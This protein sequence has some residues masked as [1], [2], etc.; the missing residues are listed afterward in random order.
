M[1][2]MVSVGAGRPYR[3]YW[4]R[5]VENLEAELA[6]PAPEPTLFE[7][8]I[9]VVRA[10]IVQRVGRVR[11]ERNLSAAHP[12]IR[13]LLDKDEAR[14]PKRGDPSWRS[15]YEKPLFDSGFERHRLRILNA[16]R[17]VAT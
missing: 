17:R 5:S 16:A 7:E 15:G 1:P 2:H 4:P 11:F 10:R 6:E 14:R 9:E 3:S 12:L 8:P 13:T